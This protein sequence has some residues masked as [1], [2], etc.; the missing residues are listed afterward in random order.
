MDWLFKSQELYVVIVSIIGLHIGSFLNVVI[1]RLPKM[2]EMQ[3][4][5]ECHSCFPNETVKP[6]ITEP[7]N[8]SLPRSHCPVCKTQL[9]VIDNIPILS[10]LFLK[11]KCHHCKTSISIRYPLIELFTAV[12]AGITAY[13]LPPSYWSLSLVAVTFVLIALS[14]IDIDTQLLPDQI[15]LPLMWSGML[16]ALFEVSPISLQDSVAGAMAGYLALWSVFHIFKL[17]TGK[18]GMG[19]GDFKLLAALGAWL[20]WQS[21]PMVILIASLAGA[22][23]GLFMMKMKN[24]EKDTPLPFGPYLAIAGWVSLLWGNQITQLYLTSY[25]GL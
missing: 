6:K 9:R 17:I 2:M 15:T 12:L 4:Q 13:I 3:W 16:L 8:L 19:Y 24:T 23:V 14:F 25:L 21:L 22:I 11:G 18:E 10:W 1:Y 20:G 5:E 7:L